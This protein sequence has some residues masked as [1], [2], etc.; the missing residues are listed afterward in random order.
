M[1]PSYSSSSS[2]LN[3]DHNVVIYWSE[4]F[5]SLAG[6]G[7]GTARAADQGLTYW[8]TGLPKVY[9][10]YI[11]TGTYLKVLIAHPYKMVFSSPELA[12]G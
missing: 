11:H 4:R 2:L 10:A 3:S 8:A 6:F 5:P 1:E 7:P 9:E 12:Q